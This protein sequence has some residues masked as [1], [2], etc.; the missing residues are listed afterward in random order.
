MPPQIVSDNATVLD[1][2]PEPEGWFDDAQS[3]IEAWVAKY[4]GGQEDDG[5]P[6]N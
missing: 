2:E 4:I 6:A 3:D 1:L 5:E